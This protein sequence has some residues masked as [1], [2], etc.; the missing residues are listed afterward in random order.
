MIVQTH[1]FR[2]LLVAA[3]CVMLVACEGLV[4][5]DQASTHALTQNADGGFEPITLDLTPE[6]TPVA[7]NFKGM[8]VANLAENSR[9][10][11]YDAR[12]AHGDTVVATK[13]VTINNTGAGNHP[14]G[15]AFAHTLFF[16][17]IPEAG[18]YRLTLEPARPR[19]ITIEEP[20]IEVR[21][22]TQPPPQR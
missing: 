16:V 13:T 11:T 6:M 19:E 12:L 14:Q 2:R 17:T 18:E 8:T 15:G 7:I 3:A 10:N 9:W 21:R 4:S 20:S 22:N 5:G 1:A